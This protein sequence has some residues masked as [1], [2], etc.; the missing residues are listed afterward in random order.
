M[1]DKFKEKLKSYLSD[2]KDKFVI[3]SEWNGSTEAGF[4]DTEE[5]DM[6][7]LMNLIDEFSEEFKSKTKGKS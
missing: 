7:S 3:V 5:V 2:N 4:Y 6:D 1:I